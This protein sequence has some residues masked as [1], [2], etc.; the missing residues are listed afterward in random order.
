VATGCGPADPYAEL[1]HSVGHHSAVSLPVI[2]S[3]WQHTRRGL[4]IG[5]NLAGHHVL[6]TCRDPVVL[7]VPPYFSPVG[8]IPLWRSRARFSLTALLFGCSSPN[9]RLD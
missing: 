9:A 4:D 3:A 8:W 2:S 1:R 5:G 7:G 6:G